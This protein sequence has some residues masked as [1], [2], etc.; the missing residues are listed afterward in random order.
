MIPNYPEIYC[1]AMRLTNGKPTITNL[2]P[3]ILIT[4][5]VTT[6]GRS[7]SQITNY[8]SVGVASRREALASLRPRGDAKSE[9]A[10]LR[11]TN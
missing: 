8:V 7:P 4:N 6:A 5:Y 3:R 11:I 10:S 1:F 9:R 2:F